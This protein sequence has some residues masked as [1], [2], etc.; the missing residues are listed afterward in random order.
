MS[1]IVRGDFDGNGAISSADALY[2][3]HYR[4][5]PEEYPVNQS[6]DVNGDGRV[7]VDDAIYLLNYF[8]YPEEY[9]LS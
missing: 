4:F 2:L 9:P 3:L 8:F 5:Y 1:R 7:N 6:G